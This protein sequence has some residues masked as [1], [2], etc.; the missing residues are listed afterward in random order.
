MQS[1]IYMNAVNA[2]GGG[3]ADDECRDWDF[4]DSLGDDELGE[5]EDEGSGKEKGERR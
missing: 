3:M 1:K 2:Y 4:I 5:E